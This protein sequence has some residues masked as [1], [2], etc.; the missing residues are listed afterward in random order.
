MPTNDAR[1]KSFVNIMS[2]RANYLYLLFRTRLSLSY[3][4]SCALSGWNK[5][6]NTTKQRVNWPDE[7]IRGH[8]YPWISSVFL[9]PMR[10]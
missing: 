9:P 3:A 10:T 8:R 4:G 5:F 2:D 1:E 6:V 7:P